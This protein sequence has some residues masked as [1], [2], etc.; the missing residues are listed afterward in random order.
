MKNTVLL[1]ATVTMLTSLS[2]QAL[3]LEEARRMAHCNYPA[4]HQYQM[5]EQS[6][7]FTIDNVAKGWF[8]KV[9]ATAGAYGFT[10]ILKAN[11]Q[12]SKMGI[13]TKN[14]M[15]SASVT[16]TQSIYD[17][18]LTA[19]QRQVASAQS[20]VQRRQ[21]DVS[22]Y[23]VNER[24]DQLFF[25]ILLIDEQLKQNQLLLADLATSEQTIR[26]MIKSGVANQGDLES[27]LVEKLKVEQQREAL[28]ASRKSYLRMLG[29]FIGKTLTENEAIEKPTSITSFGQSAVNRPE[30]AY[31]LSQN[32]LLD[33]QRKQTDSRL[34]PT[35]NLFGMGIIHSKVSQLFNPGILMGGVSV[36]WNIGA[37][38]TH[39]ND[40]RKIEVQKAINESERQIFLF[41]NRLQNEENIGAIESLRKQIAQDEEIVK[42]RESIR[43][44]SD[45]K[46][47]LGTESVNELIRD[48]HAVS[49]ARAQKAQH[50][51]ELL[52]E[53]YNQ[54][55][56]NNE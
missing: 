15:T 42:L 9:S 46:V 52:K 4:I 22:M 50:E 36:S 56:I 27:I 10:D 11:A 33:A 38:Y 51:I 41:Q 5:I 16:V 1:L 18:G 49:M 13:D 8:P 53:I 14:W 6:R 35:I 24:I 25:G 20:E 44:K 32:I 47:Q 17:G 40:L 39:K 28:K 34:R 23:A 19:A 29:V 30:M 26:S 2:A 45:K 21:L 3:S 43:N 54:K 12:M 48:I 55:Y 7:D 37:L 31:Y